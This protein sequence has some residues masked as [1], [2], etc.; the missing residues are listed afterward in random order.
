MIFDENIIKTK[1]WFQ[2]YDDNSQKFYDYILKIN[3]IHIHTML[4]TNHYLYFA[5]ETVN[6]IK[7]F[8]YVFVRILNKFTPIFFYKN[9]QNLRTKAFFSA[10]RT[11][12]RTKKG[13]YFSLGT[14]KG[15]FKFWF[16]F[17]DFFKNYLTNLI[18]F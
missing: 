16:L 1:R 4:L 17:L 10:I 8:I 9:Q 2:F 15:F 13:F 12:I 3:F 11:K 18:F 6:L 5:H 14:K 7:Y